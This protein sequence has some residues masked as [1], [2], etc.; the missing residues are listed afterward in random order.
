MI[1]KSQI[2]KLGER[3]VESNPNEADLR[4]LD[5]YRRSFGEAYDV[6]VQS[7]RDQLRLEPTGRPA[8]STT[9]I[10]EK[11]RRE[12]IRLSQIQD[13]AGC[14][15]VL[16]GIAEQDNAVAGFT[17]LFPGSA[18]VDRRS[19]PSFGYRAV[20]VIVTIQGCRVEVQFRTGLQQNWAQLSEKMSDVIDPSLKYGGN[21]QFQPFLR[22]QSGLI[23]Q[24]EDLERTFA[25]LPE[26]ELKQPAI[27]ALQ[28]IKNSLNS[29]LGSLVKRIEGMERGDKN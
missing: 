22:N 7:I 1:S 19:K 28:S 16:S 11:L 25:E 12:S 15:I 5:Q 23:A 13:I 20:H 29:V 9:S 18:V 2:D 4:L 24:I 27:A 8:K 17:R 10:V 3:L 26:S 14:R 6:V 21:E